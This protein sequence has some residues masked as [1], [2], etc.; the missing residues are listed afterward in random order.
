MRD[1]TKWSMGP[2]SRH[3]RA[4]PAGWTLTAAPAARP[5]RAAS[6][7]LLSLS[8]T[9]RFPSSAGS[10]S[11]CNKI[12]TL[13]EELRGPS[14]PVSLTASSKPHCQQQAPLC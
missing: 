5:P 10:S 1:G 14:F 9:P 7:V 6:A 4:H 8:L 12:Q 2:G 11:T 3:P 13:P